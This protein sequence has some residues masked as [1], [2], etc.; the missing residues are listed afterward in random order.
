MHFGAAARILVVGYLLRT[1]FRKR[2]VKAVSVAALAVL[3][4]ICW[5]WAAAQASSPVAQEAKQPELL[6][7]RDGPL[8]PA[9]QGGAPAVRAAASAGKTVAER[10]AE[11]LEAARK[12]QLVPAGHGSPGSFP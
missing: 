8:S 1:C 9:G 11:T 4:S 3:G 6:A 10:K 7:S 12:G 2:P 5:Q